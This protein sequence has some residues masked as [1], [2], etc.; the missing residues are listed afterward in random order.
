MRLKPCCIINS[1]LKVVE[2]GMSL[3][4]MRY[5]FEKYRILHYQFLYISIFL[6]VY[7][8]Y[9]NN[10]MIMV[11][12]VTMHENGIQLWFTAATATT[13]RT[14]WRPVMVNRKS[15]QQPQP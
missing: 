10:I 13:A 12:D 11:L 2:D 6:C 5:V 8:A 1:T 9:F 15:A 4:Q 3:T 7:A 14:T